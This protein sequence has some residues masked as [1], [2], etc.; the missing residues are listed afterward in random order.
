MVKKQTTQDNDW[1]DV[2]RAPIFKF[3]KKGDV[4]Q[5]LLK[6]KGS[7]MTK[8]GKE[9]GIYKILTSDNQLYTV[10]GLTLLDRLMSN[11]NVNDEV[12]IEYVGK[13]KGK[14]N[15]TRH[16]FIVKKRTVATS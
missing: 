11:V 10:F 16:E 5:G 13:V 6:S 15:T 14:N 7:F 12:Y 4:I 2:S 9:R 3:Q 8:F 1:I